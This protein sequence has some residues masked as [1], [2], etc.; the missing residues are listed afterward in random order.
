[1]RALAAA[2]AEVRAEG[3]GEA[4]DV[5]L[6]A[7]RAPDV[8]DPEVAGRAVEGHAPRVAQA[9]AQDLPARAREPHERIVGGDVGRRRVDVEAQHLAEDRA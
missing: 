3:R 7:V 1:M 2:P 9:E 4:H 5:D 6:F 8:A